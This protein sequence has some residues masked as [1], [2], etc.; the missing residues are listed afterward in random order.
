MIKGVKEGHK[1]EL[2]IQGIGFRAALQGKK[3]VF[4]LGFSHPVE[5]QIPE[6]VTVTVPKSNNQLPLKAITQ[7]ELVR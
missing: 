7:K 2:E 4:I 1:K 3:I 6:D 5:F